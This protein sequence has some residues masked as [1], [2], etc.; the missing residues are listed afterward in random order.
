MVSR[1]PYGMLSSIIS[2]P[3]TTSKE[4]KPLKILLNSEITYNDFSFLLI[5]FLSLNIISFSYLSKILINGIV[6]QNSYFKFNLNLIEG[7][8]SSIL[9]QI[10]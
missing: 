4:Y 6:K 5:I 2:C 8:Y 1:I 10:L 7:R 9:F 3:I